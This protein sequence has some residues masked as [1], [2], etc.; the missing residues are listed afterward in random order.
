MTAAHAQPAGPGVK[1][2]GALQMV[3]V[4]LIDTDGKNLRRE[5]GDVSRLRSSFESVGMLQPLTLRL[6][7]AGR[8]ELVAGHRR[9]SAAVQSGA[10]E[11]PAIV[12]EMNE[13][14]KW[15]ARLGENLHR[16][17]LTP[18]DEGACTASC[19][20]T[21]TPSASWHRWPGGRSATS[22]SE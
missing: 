15:K 21:A 19:P 11:V 9:L 14:Q 3:A 1:A 18:S 17:D 12:R 4:A 10:L 5:N 7:P 16:R 2:P 6:M 20:C 8:Y 22:A 13:R